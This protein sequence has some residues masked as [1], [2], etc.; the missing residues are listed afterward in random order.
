MASKN[1]K[2]FEVQQGETISDCLDR[3]KK[4][5]YTPVRRFEKPVFTE[6]VVDGKKEY[7]PT[8]RKITFEGK[9][10]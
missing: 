6:K 10:L 5:G 3:M 7:I 8:E 1:K 9:K 2:T 4:E